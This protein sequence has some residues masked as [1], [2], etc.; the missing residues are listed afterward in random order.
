[1]FQPAGAGT[2]FALSF[3]ERLVHQD[4]NAEKQICE[5]TPGCDANGWDAEISPYLASSVT[6]EY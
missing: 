6:R 5:T 3:P 2:L 4:I 1:M